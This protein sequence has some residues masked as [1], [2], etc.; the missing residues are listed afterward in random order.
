MQNI[1]ILLIYWEA[2]LTN[3]EQFRYMKIA[4]ERETE[5]FSSLHFFPSFFF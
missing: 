5:S 1:Y 2:F 4:T 3:V